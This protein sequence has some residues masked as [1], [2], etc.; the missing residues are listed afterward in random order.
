M[1]VL[2]QT[3][4]PTEKYRLNGY[5]SNLLTIPASSLRLWLFDAL[6]LTLGQ[7]RTTH[8]KQRYSLLRMNGTIP[9]H[10]R[11]DCASCLACA[12]RQHC[13]LLRRISWPAIGARILQR[14]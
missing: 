12:L 9:R 13:L 14:I 5:L 10:A 6:A 2:W 3:P 8:R 11:I 4:T 7:V 1:S